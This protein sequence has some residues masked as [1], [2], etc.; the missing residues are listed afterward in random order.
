MQEFRMQE[1]RN[2]MLEVRCRG[3]PCGR[4]CESARD[5]IARQ[6]SGC[7][8]GATLVVAMGICRMS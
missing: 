8:V 4:P 1:C 6:L 3:D 2:L 7:W 5:A